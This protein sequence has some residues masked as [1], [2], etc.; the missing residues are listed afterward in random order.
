[1]KLKRR[2]CSARQRA[3]VDGAVDAYTQ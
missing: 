1:M 3:L 2:K